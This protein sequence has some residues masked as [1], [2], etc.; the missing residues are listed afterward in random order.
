[1]DSLRPWGRNGFIWT[2]GTFTCFSPTLGIM[3]A[4]GFRLVELHHFS[5]EQNPYGWLQSLL[6]LAGLPENSLYGILKNSPDARPGRL[7]P[8]QKA[9]ALLL[10]G[11]LLPHSIYLSVLMALLHRGT[12]EACSEEKSSGVRENSILAVR[13]S[14]HDTQESFQQPARRVSGF[15]GF[16]KAK[17]ETNE[18]IFS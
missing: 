1:M 16:Q 14:P 12:I 10:A 15:S 18:E 17:N 4:L 3:E 13:A 11:G 6:N 9:K 2:L 7:S 5:M 8:L